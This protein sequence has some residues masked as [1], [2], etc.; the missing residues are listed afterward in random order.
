MTDSARY[1]VVGCSECS[2]HW[3]VDLHEQAESS[4][5]PRCG[6]RRHIS[7]RRKMAYA[8]DH[9]KAAEL[10]ARILANRAGKGEKYKGSDDFGTLAR[11]LDEVPQGSDLFADAAEEALGLADDTN[12][13]S[14]KTDLTT[15]PGSGP[16]VDV[17]VADR[18]QLD[19]GPIQP[20]VEPGLQLVDPGGQVNISGIVTHDLPP[21]RSEWLPDLNEELIPYTTRLVQDLAEDRDWPVQEF[22]RITS[23]VDHVLADDVVDLEG[24]DITTGAKQEVRAYFEAAARYAFLW[25]DE[26]YRDARGFEGERQ[27]EL[28]EDT[29]RDL[30]TGGGQFNAGFEA[31]RHSL[32]Q[33]H[34]QREHPL[35]LTFNLS[36]EDWVDAEPETVRK[37]LRAFDALAEAF[38][39]RLLV[40]TG[41]WSMIQRLVSN[42]GDDRGEADDDAETDVPGWVERYERLIDE[43][44]TSRRRGPD[45]GA[46]KE[47]DLQREAWTYVQENS[48]QTGLLTTLANLDADDDRSVMSLKRDTEIDYADA[49]IDVWCDDLEQ[50][51]LVSVDRA[52]A[53]NRLSLTSLGVAAQ[54]FVASDGS[55]VHPDQSRLDG[56]SYGHPSASRKYS[57]AR[58][59][60]GGVGRPPAERWLA[61]TGAPGEDSSFVEWL[62][63]RGGRREVDPL[64]LHRRFEA[65]NRVE[66]VNLVDDHLIRWGDTDAENLPDGDGRKV[67]TSCFDDHMVVAYQW[68]GSMASLVRPICGLLDNKSLSKVLDIDTVGTQFQNLHDGVNSFENDLE[69][70]LQRAQQIGWLSEDELAHYDSWR[71]RIA[72][73]KALLLSKMSELDE[74]DN[75]LRRELMNDLQGLLTSATHM[76]HAAGIEITTVVR[77]PD[78]DE[79]VDDEKRYQD[80]LDFLR[81]TVT[82]Q[83]GYEDENGFHSIYRMLIEDRPKKL[84]S[85]SPYDIDQAAPTADLTMNWQVVGPGVS[86]FQEDI[87]E[88][89]AKETERLREPID[90]GQED[91]ALLEIPIVGANSHGHTRNLIREIGEQKGFDRRHRDD[92]DRLSRALEAALATDDWAPSPYLVA[93]VLDSLES[94]DRPWDELTVQALENGLATLPSDCIFS[95]LKPA[96]QAML[97]ALLEADEPLSR[98]DLIE[99]TSES[100]YDRH[101]KDLKAFWLVEETEDGGLVAHI[102]P[103]WASTN[104][105]TEP[106][107]EDHPNPASQPAGQTVRSG[108][109]GNPG[110]ILLLA[111]DGADGSVIPPDKFR[112]LG[113]RGSATNPDWREIL[114]DLGY[115]EW[116]T[117][118]RAY[119]D[120]WTETISEPYS[121]PSAVRIGPEPVSH[122]E[123]QA[124]LQAVAGD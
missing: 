97:S 72:D 88:A 105:A 63:D 7:K 56:S 59:E 122:D 1:A 92:L 12:N 50:H 3:I 11:T 123:Q 25:D 47:R 37:S 106:F 124:S 43:R 9:Q 113:V 4:E 77:M 119:C 27:F 42:A 81:Y 65:G 41:V 45:E 16:D 76:F 30:G 33:L 86:A 73:L 14:E 112:E 31:F 26:D 104:E 18:P 103:W 90:E 114:D 10:R 116:A 108:P 70:V 2:S 82:K 52:H 17:H 94:R 64:I 121:D 107:Q 58:H 95:E 35:V 89:I 79:L 5:C 98:Q 68:G 80:F 71:D 83:A 93:D 55:V 115:G 74:M 84:K 53:S 110:D 67:Y 46:E 69:D 28:V 87:E 32:V 23:F 96:Q 49:S 61:E 20:G 29:L 44:T 78:V 57:V 19:A 39:V 62:G 36:G 13:S 85:R 51:G 24:A 101:H 99:V 54:E 91:A 40:S 75:G 6:H 34:E 102:E 117:I 15:D 100:S 118:F 111:E 66:G 120:Q 60:I 22:G 38:D 21:Q 48:G 109:R 8:D